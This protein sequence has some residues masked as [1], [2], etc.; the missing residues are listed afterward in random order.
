EIVELPARTVCVAAGT[1]PNVM[2]EKER[3]G[4][5]KMDKWKQFFQAH[6]ATVDESG[7]LVVEPVENPKEGFFTSYSD[8]RHAVSYYGDNHPSCAGRVVKARASAKDASPHAVALSRRDI[9]R[10]GD[11]PQAARDERRR[12]LFSKLDDE[13]IATVHEVRRLT[14]TI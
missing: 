14:A 3:P 10:L 9:E 7:R 6:K 12:A 11:E 1:S 2:Y 8:G 4:S 5:F 13:L